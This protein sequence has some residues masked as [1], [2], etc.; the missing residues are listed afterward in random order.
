MM[1]LDPN[2]KV[3]GSP[4]DDTLKSLLS[5]KQTVN[6]RD[7]IPTSIVKMISKCC[8]SNA[9]SLRPSRGYKFL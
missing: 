2:Y 4:L 5:W 8:Y 1:G 7:E 6:L 9:H 3:I